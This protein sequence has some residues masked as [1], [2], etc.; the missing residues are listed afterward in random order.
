MSSSTYNRSPRNRSTSGGAGG[1]GGVA[2]ELATT[3]TN[4]RLK[5]PAG[6]SPQGGAAA[7]SST[8]IAT[9]N[10]INSKMNPSKHQ[11]AQ[12]LTSTSYAALKPKH[13]LNPSASPHKKS[14]GK[15][16]IDLRPKAISTESLRSVSPGSDSVFYS[17]ADLT[18]EHQVR[19]NQWF[20]LCFPLS[21]SLFCFVF[22]ECFLLKHAMNIHNHSRFNAIIAARRWT[23]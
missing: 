21:S 14:P 10:L 18:L 2:D 16:P 4:R 6:T 5:T 3:A 19:V 23:S 20:S 22:L 9:N 12:Q 8:I 11:S 17:E 13:Y 7:L 1:G 15:S